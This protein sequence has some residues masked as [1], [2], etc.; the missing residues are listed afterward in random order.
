MNQT[1]KTK[2]LEFD[3][4]SFLIDLVKHAKGK[5]F[6]EIT[7]LIRTPNSRKPRQQSIQLNPTIIPELVAAL[8]E[9]HA[10]I[11][12]KHSVKHSLYSEEFK[13][14]IQSSY[15]KGVSIEDLALQ[16]GI[17]DEEI[18]NILRNR[19]IA[20]LSKE[21]EKKMKYGKRFWYRKK[22]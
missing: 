7:Q 14:K 5:L 2:Q 3:K 13:D 8:L 17:E 4:S 16:N 1:L 20:V 9:M 11:N 15:L 12:P 22:K 18:K 6:V 19:E 10:T 21:E